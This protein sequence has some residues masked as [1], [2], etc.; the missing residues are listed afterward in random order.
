ML[1]RLWAGAV[2]FARAPPS[3]ALCGRISPDCLVPVRRMLVFRYEAGGLGWKGKYAIRLRWRGMVIENLA[4][5]HAVKG[6]VLQA[7]D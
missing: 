1:V 4:P 7:I 5:A 6:R 3:V 2:A